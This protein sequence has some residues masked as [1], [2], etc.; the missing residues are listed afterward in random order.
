MQTCR[1]SG[2]V[3]LNPPNLDT[4][5]RRLW[6]LPSLN[7]NPETL[8]DPKPDLFLDFV[9]DPKMGSVG[10]KEG[11]NSMENGATQEKSRLT[12]VSKIVHNVEQTSF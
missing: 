12:P 4:T 1:F 11:S 6:R 9:L 3:N 5:V 10:S 8:L 2:S 7:V